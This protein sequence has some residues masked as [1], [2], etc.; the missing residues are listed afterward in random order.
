MGSVASGGGIVRADSA[1]AERNRGPILSVLSQV[2]PGQGR[3][4]EIAAG[5]GQHAGYFA[6]ALPGLTWLPTDADAD[7]VATMEARFSGRPVPNVAGPQLLDVTARPWPVNDV[8]A[9]YACNVLHI[10]PWR[11]CEALFAGAARLLGAG[12][13]LVI[14]GPFFTA[15]AVPAQGN[16]GFDARLRARNADWGIRALEDVARVAGEQG[17]A[18][19]ARVAMPA[20]NLTLVFRRQPPT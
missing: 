4:L 19:E 3:V 20:N 15:D 11:V 10:S 9:V 6:A 14:Y 17:F 7:A 2:L 8:D 18:L 13:V 1:A 12:S 5:S 16:L